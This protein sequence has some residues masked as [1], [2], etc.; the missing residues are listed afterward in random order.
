MFYFISPILPR[1]NENEKYKMTCYFSCLSK[2]MAQL[3]EQFMYLLRRVGEISNFTEL[4]HSV[5]VISIL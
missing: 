4:C 2:S 3:A 1:R 5:P